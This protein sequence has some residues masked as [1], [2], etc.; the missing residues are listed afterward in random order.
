MPRWT[1]GIL[2][3]A[4][5]LIALVASGATTVYVASERRIQRVYDPEP[6]SI[7]IPT[8]SALIAHG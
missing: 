2:A 5:I 6:T 7:V 8:D 4:L 1:K 3:A